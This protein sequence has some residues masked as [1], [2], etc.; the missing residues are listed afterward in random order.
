MKKA[1]ITVNFDEEKTVALKLYLEQ[2]GSSL[3]KELAKSL[4]SLFAKSVPVGVR[5]FIALRSG[6]SATV[7]SPKKKKQKI[8]EEKISET[9]METEE[10]RS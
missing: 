2:K 7:S 1:V 9:H 10:T 3:E 8:Q 4:D 5:Q 6:N